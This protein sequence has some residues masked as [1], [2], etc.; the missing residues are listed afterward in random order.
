MVQSQK[1]ALKIRK[2]RDTDFDALVAL[3]KSLG[4]LGTTIRPVISDYGK[5]A[6]MRK[7]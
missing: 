3:W 4:M 6:M 1:K 7:Y 2:Y 5:Q